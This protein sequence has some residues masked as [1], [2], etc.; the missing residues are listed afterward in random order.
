[1]A[2]MKI[3]CKNPEQTDKVAEILTALAQMRFEKSSKLGHYE[4][5]LKIDSYDTEVCGDIITVELM[6]LIEEFKDV[7]GIKEVYFE[8]DDYDG[9]D[10][11]DWCHIDDDALWRLY[12]EEKHNRRQISA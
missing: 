10:F 4:E 9:R 3:Y 11:E 12:H 5:L 7:L 1:M 2:T 8:A 6:N